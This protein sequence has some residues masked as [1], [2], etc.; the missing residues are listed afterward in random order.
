MPPFL[1]SQESRGGKVTEIPE[2]TLFPHENIV[3]GSAK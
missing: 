2:L 1:L 3:A